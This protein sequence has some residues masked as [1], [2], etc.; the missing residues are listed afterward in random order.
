MNFHKPVHINLF[1]IIALINIIYFIR[2]HKAL[3]CLSS[4]PNTNFSVVIM[5]DLSTRKIVMI[6]LLCAL[7]FL[8]L[9]EQLVHKSIFKYLCFVED[10]ISY[11]GKQEATSQIKENK[12]NKI[13]DIYI[14]PYFLHY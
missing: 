4:Q 6:I 1:I 2:N 7:S 12:I 9:L 8:V 3:F 10:N 5:V 13:K 14:S 11:L